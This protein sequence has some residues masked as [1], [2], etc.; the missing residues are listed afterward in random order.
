MDAAFFSN[1]FNVANG[2]LSGS[3]R[4][5]SVATFKMPERLFVSGSYGASKF[6][7][8]SPSPFDG[9]FDLGRS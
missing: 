1:T 8:A 7:F 5:L 3:V 6:D 9:Q 2:R 4:S